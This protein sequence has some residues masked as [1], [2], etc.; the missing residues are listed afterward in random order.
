MRKGRKKKARSTKGKSDLAGMVGNLDKCPKTNGK[1]EEKE[2]A[3]AGTMLTGPQIGEN[4]KLHPEDS[5]CIAS[6]WRSRL[7]FPGA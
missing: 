1:S 6:H 2:K 7:S 3:I 4:E 5:K